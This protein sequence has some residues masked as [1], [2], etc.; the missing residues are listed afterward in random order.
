MFFR[1]ILLLTTFNQALA[2]Q[3]APLNDQH[4]PP[5]TAITLAPHL[6]ELVYSAGGGQALV[7]V[8]AYSDYPEAVSK[9][10]I[11]GD[12]FHLNLEL[13]KQLNPDV[14]FYWPGGTPQQTINKLNKMG[15]HLVAIKTTQLSDIPEAID[16][17]AQTLGTQAVDATHGFVQTINQLKTKVKSQ[18]S[19]LIQISDQPIYTVDSSHWMSEAIEVCGLK[20]IFSQLPTASAAVNLEAVVLKKPQVLVR[21]KPLAKDSQLSQWQRIPAIQNQ[22]IA[23]LDADHFTRP[24]LRTLLAIESLCEQVKTFEKSSIQAVLT[25]QFQVLIVHGFE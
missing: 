3:T 6:T 17:I 20:N 13:I 7:G 1:I 11:I 14:I 18:R 9:K 24:T 8:S 5:V 2:A 22:H 23:V 19:A 15:H 16:Q 21:I 10:Q 25:Q 12:A 4:N